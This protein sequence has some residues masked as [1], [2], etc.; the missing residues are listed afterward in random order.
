MGRRRSILRHVRRSYILKGDWMEV[1]DLC[2]NDDSAT[3]AMFR[4]ILLEAQTGGD[5]NAKNYLSLDDKV[6]HHDAFHLLVD[7]GKAIAFAGLFNDDIYPDT[8]ARVLNRA[9]YAKSVR[10]SGLPT[11]KHKRHNGGLLARHILPKQIEIARQNRQAV[12]FSIEFNRRQ[13][14]IHTITEWMNQYDRV[15]DE[16][17]TAMEDMYFTCPAYESCVTNLTCWQNVAVLKFNNSFDFPL[18]RKTR[19]E[20][21][22]EFG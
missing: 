6:Q 2:N 14:T 13:R 15:H 1:I 5:R 20:W 8:I 9:Y 10:Q 18:S 12:F 22:H 11:N 21:K 3:W 4:E 16:I 7:E 17:W 19:E